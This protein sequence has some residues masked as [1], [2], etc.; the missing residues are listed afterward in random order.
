MEQLLA[1]HPGRG[2]LPGH[3]DAL[4]QLSELFDLQRVVIPL[5]ELDHPGFL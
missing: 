3:A 4:V 1:A 2:H 5:V